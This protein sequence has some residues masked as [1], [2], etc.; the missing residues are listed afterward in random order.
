MPA[1][2]HLQNLGTFGPGRNIL[3][4]I[5]LKDVANA[6]SLVLGGALSVKA[7]GEGDK[8]FCEPIYFCFHA[9]SVRV[10]FFL[11]P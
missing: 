6:V 3:S 8:G 7:L 5:H 11:S 1:T 2:N 9:T 10:D 4:L